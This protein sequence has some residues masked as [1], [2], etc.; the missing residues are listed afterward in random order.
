MEPPPFVEAP[1][2]RTALAQTYL[3]THTS[4]ARTYRE[5]D[6]CSRPALLRIPVPSPPS[7]LKQLSFVPINWNSLASAFTRV[8]TL[9]R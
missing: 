2:A 3:N 8:V 1:Y 9:P 5:E 6:M 4:H 7:I